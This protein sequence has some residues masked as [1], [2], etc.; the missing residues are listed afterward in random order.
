MA[1]CPFADLSSPDLH[2]GGVPADLYRELRAARAVRVDQP[3]SGGEGFWAFFRQEDVDRISKHPLQFSSALK[4]CF[5]NDVP[6]DQIDLLR[7]MIINMDPPEHIKYRRIIRNAFTPA[8]VESY[9]PRFREIVREAVAAVLPRGECEFVTDIACVLPLI[10]ICEI[11]GVPIEDRRRF[12]EW[13]NIMLGGDDPDL[14]T[15]PEAAAMA[16]AELYMYSDKVMEQHRANPRDDIVGALLRGTVAGEHLSEEEFRNFMMLLIVAGNETTRT[17]T[18]HGMRL[19][20][21]HP[22][23]YRMLV[24]D[25]TLIPDAV[26]EILRFNPAVINFR[27]TVTEPTEVGGQP[28]QPGDKVVMFYQAASRDETLFEDP[29]RFDITRPRREDVRNEHRAFGIGEHFCLGSHLARLEL[30]IVF[31]E[32]VRHIRNPRTNG[33]IKW[34][35]SN[36][37]HGIKEMK[38]IFD[39]A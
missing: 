21:E 14:S 27:R 17:V 30:I 29:D 9:A 36:F 12:F 15:S 19:L 18:S 22:E 39:V 10:A 28:L 31:E 7:T 11:L 16:A 32:I 24:E 35:R 33:E 34:L 26:E 8:K 37:I 4:T 25:P 13:T 1:S 2:R 3:M 38:I 5:L 6:P 23:Q 20:M